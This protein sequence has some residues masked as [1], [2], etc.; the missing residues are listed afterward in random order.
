MLVAANPPPSLVIFPV[1]HAW[2]EP[3]DLDLIRQSAIELL[4][5][6]AAQGWKTVLLPRP[7]CGNGQL[8]WDQVRPV[9]A[10]FLND[11]FVVVHL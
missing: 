2:Y 4:T 1:K 5:L 6:T 11:R 10:P 3:A 7:G 8:T 9:I